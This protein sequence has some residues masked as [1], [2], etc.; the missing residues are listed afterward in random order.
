MRVGYLR[1]QVID[2]SD[3]LRPLIPEVLLDLDVVSL[4]NMFLTL[5]AKNER[6]ILIF[7]L[8]LTLLIHFLDVFDL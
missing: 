7:E 4:I 1:F 5:Q 2:L 6:I 3:Q 8:R